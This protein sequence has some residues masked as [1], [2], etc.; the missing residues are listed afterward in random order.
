[1]SYQRNVGGFV[2]VLCNNVYVSGDMVYANSFAQQNIYEYLL[3]FLKEFVDDKFGKLLEDKLRQR[4][5]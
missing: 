5:R 4:T 3:H 1:M 2:D